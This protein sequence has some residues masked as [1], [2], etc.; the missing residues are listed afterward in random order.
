MAYEVHPEI[1]SYGD[2]VGNFFQGYQ[3]AFIP[4]QMKAQ[5]QEYKD[6]RSMDALNRQYIQAKIDQMNSPQEDPANKIGFSGDV[7]NAVSVENLARM[8]GEQD[9]R[10]MAARKSLADQQQYQNALVAYRNSLMNTIDKRTASPFAKTQQ[11]IDDIKNGFMPGTGRKDTL[12]DQEQDALLDL[13]NQDNLKKTTDPRTRARGLSAI[14]IEKTIES[15]DPQALFQYSGPQGAARKAYDASQAALGKAPENYNNYM[16]ALNSSR[17]LAHQ[18]RQFYEDS[19]QPSMLAQLESFTNPESA[20][21]DSST[22]LSQYNKFTN[23]LG[24]ETGTILDALKSPEVYNYKKGS[25]NTESNKDQQSVN[26]YH[27]KDLLTFSN[28][29]TLTAEEAKKKGYI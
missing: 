3:A 26:D 5:Q 22:A 6:K 25:S 19:I 14:N 2:P 17:L 15:I 1:Y 20:F 10:V 29:E 8:Y 12:T 16:N 18:V 24:K 27:E 7:A 4:Q 13:Y 21:K 28:G 11:E 9:P 23:I